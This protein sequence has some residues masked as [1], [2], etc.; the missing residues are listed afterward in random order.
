[1]RLDEKVFLLGY[2]SSKSQAQHLIKDQKVLVNGQVV[3]RPGKII[4][5]SHSVTILEKQQYVSRGSYKLLQALKH[6]NIQV[7]GKICAD[8]GA[9]T[10]GFTQILLE[11]QAQKVY[12]IDVG[13]DQLH[14]KIKA[15]KKVVDLS[16]T[17][18]KEAN[19]PEKVDLLVADLSFISIQKVFDHLL[20]LTK[21]KAELVLLF[22]PQFEVGPENL[23]KKGIANPKAAKEALSN[24]LNNI[25][26]SKYRVDFTE[27]PIKGQDG[28]TE[29]LIYICK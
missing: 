10:G 15:N 4:S 14:P 8:I 6:W 12:A 20:L 18:I 17:N 19:L 13:T 1:M 23:N 7:E 9:S 21:V 24:F 28:N 3:T 25:V 27:S 26:K 29:Y 11:S 16:R 22:K 2:A 5:T